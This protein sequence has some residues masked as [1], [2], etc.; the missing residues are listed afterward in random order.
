MNQRGGCG[1][2]FSPVIQT[3]KCMNHSAENNKGGVT[4]TDVTL[5][6]YGQNVPAVGLDIFTPE[7]RLEIASRLMEAGLKNIEI[8]SCIHPGI[9]PAMNKKALKK[10]AAGLGRVDGVHLITLVP[11]TAG[12]RNFLDMGLGPN[13]Y[14]HTMGIFFSAVEAHNLANLGRPIRETLDEYKKIAV[15]ALAKKIRMVAYISAVFGYFD[16]KE[17]ILIEADMEE[18]KSY[19][20]LLFDLGAQTVTLSDL[21]GVAN[22]EK[23]GRI[24]EEILNRKKGKDREK[25]GYHPHNISDEAA[26]ANSK[27]AYSLG[28][29]RFDGSIG[30]TGG[31]ITGAPGNQS[32]ER[33]VQSFHESGI[34]TGLG[35]QKIFALKDMIERELFKKIS[36][37]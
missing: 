26:I 12:Y 30:G 17:T 29:R 10:I 1:H 25:L 23:T 27:T 22:E 18:V 34:E 2:L 6:E 37:Q 31:C 14:N 9:A 24:F 16:S 35:E 3:E 28:I 5:R 4:I 21:Q 36:L 11:N 19:I 15:D 33:L 8:L 7:I 13:G 32:T 20:D